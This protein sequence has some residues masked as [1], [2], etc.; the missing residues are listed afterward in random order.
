MIRWLTLFLLL[1]LAAV[2]AVYWPHAN[3]NSPGTALIPGGASQDILSISITDADGQNVQLSH[4]EGKWLLD[5]TLP[6][7]ATKIEDLLGALLER[8][9]GYAIAN[10]E[11]AATRFEVSE[12]A[13]ER[14]IVLD[15]NAGSQTAYLGSSPAF[16]KVHA[17]REGDPAVY[18]LDLNSYDAPAD[19]NSWLD[20]GLLALRNQQRMTLNDLTFRLEQDSWINDSG[21]PIDSDAMDTLLQALAGLLVSAIEQQDI[22]EAE[23]VLSIRASS[24]DQDSTLEILEDSED[25][26]YFLRSN[27]FAPVF[28][29]SAY[30]AERILDAVAALGGA[31]PD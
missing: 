8:D 22:T 26:R 11:S 18:V 31:L 14:R 28:A 20:K 27:R 25:E 29:T 21:E 24:G 23:V 16:R 19:A 9:P 5:S 1:Q 4:R 17:R 6:A 30:D 7:N 13:F 15:S 2:V 10:S 3:G 12:D